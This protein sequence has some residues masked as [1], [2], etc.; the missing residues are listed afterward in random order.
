MSFED[1]FKLHDKGSGKSVCILN[2][3]RFGLSS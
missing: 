3:T 1:L 2:G